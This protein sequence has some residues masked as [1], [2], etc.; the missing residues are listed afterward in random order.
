MQVTLQDSFAPPSWLA[1][2]HVQSI[3]P[4]MPWRRSLV[5]RRAESLRRLSR[6]V[7]LECGEG[8]RHGGY[9]AEPIT[10]TT[11]MVVLLHGWEGSA[12]SQY[13]LS[14]GQHLLAQ[15]YA[16]F[17]LNFRD[18]GG[19]HHLNPELFH[20]CRI[21]EVIGAVR[22]VQAR[23]ASMSLSLVGYSLGGN[24]AL[25]VAARAERAGLRL[26]KVIA[27]CPVLDPAHT[28]RAL[29][30][31][32]YLY[33]RY[34]IHKWRNSLLQKQAAWPDRYGH[35][36]FPRYRGL[37][38]MTEALVLRHAG[39]PD[40]ES[41]LNGYAIVG[42]ALGGLSVRSRII[43]AADDPIIPEVDLERLAAPA[44]L[45][46]TRVARGGHCGF[47]DSIAGPSWA[48]RHI[49]RLLDAAYAATVG[50]DQRPR[51]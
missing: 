13:M 34:F 35:D 15:G 33:R 48:D 32:S 37:V 28:L 9:C 24:F 7:I 45:T 44:M 51:S 40:L 47:L 42:N 17:R 10:P 3:L 20:S 8:V 49:G 39:Y 46:V 25:R 5:W 22:A 12:D 19:T 43:A 21:D 38:E 14:L 6:S 11:R 50:E 18:H 36:D 27:V 4:S 23:H 2:P 41:Y 30:N 1:N 31:G 26:R 29:E 16:V